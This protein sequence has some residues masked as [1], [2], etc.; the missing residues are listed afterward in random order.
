MPDAREALQALDPRRTAL[1]VIDMQNAFAHPEGALGASGV[2]MSG[3]GA[4][5]A[6]TRTLIETCRAAGVTVLWTV[7][8]HLQG[9]ATRS[10]K[11]LGSHVGK[12]VRVP[13][14]EGTWDAE[15]VEELAPLADEPMHVIDKHRFGAFYDTRLETLLRARGLDTLLVTG[16]TANACVETTLREAYLRDLDVVAVV[17]CIIGVRQDWFE[18]VQQIWSHYLCQLATAGDVEAWLTGD[19]AVVGS[20]S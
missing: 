19:R 8:H 12:R 18:T 11:R 6:R 15:L 5:I 7:Q 14:E 20:G 1:L 16:A 3:A 9:D 17:D 4:V 2:D 10:R 13:A